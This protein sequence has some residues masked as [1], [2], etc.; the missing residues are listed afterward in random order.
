[1]Q[2]NNQALIGHLAVFGAY[3]IFGMNILF[4]KDLTNT[5]RIP[6]ILL[7][8]IRAAGATVLFWL[9]SL[10]TPKEKVE[11]K[12]FPQIALASFIGLFITQYFFLKII[13]VSTAID[14]AVIGTLTPV[15]TMIFAAIFIGEPIS[16]RKAGGVAISLI[17]ALL[18]IFNSVRAPGG[19]E[20][21]T[22]FGWVGLFINVS[23]FAAYLGIFRPLIAK[24]SV[25]TF[26]KWMFL[27]SFVMTLPFSLHESMNFDFSIIQGKILFELGYLVILAT[28]VAY[29]LIPVAQK[30]LRPTIVSM[31]SY[32][33]P[34]I[35]AVVGI[36]VGLDTLSWLK[37][38]STLLVFFGV[39][40][41]NQSG[42]KAA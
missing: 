33:Q 35:A 28:Y 42:A 14:V 2:K 8:S 27:F 25:V 30:R 17:G 21:T 38:V 37:V 39:W 32:M 4:C 26:M 3:L 16:G 12:D 6:P 10:F 19:V 7:F 1:M 20:H 41:V 34:I 11:K 9:T 13:Y 40:V 18:L 5:V 22:A 15:F 36:A 29:F 24:Y 23:A 31:Y